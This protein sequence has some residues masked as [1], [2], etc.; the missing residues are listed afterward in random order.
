MSDT[1]ITAFYVTL[2]GEVQGIGLRR[3]I[4]AAARKRDLKGWVRN[5]K[6]GHVQLHVEGVEPEAR[7]LIA[8]LQ[9]GAIEAD[10]GDIVVTRTAPAGFEEFTIAKRADLARIV[11][12]L[13]RAALDRARRLEGEY[14]DINDTALNLLDA[15]GDDQSDLAE[16]M[17]RIP[18]RFL[19]EPFLQRQRAMQ[20]KISDVACSFASES[21]GHHAFQQALKRYIGY[22]PGGVIDNKARG[23]AFARRIG[24]RV[25]QTYQH[26]VPLSKIEIRAGVVIKPVRGAGSTGVFSV[27]TPDNIFS[28]GNHKHLSSLEEFESEA[29]RCA[30]TQKAGDRWMV[31]D[32]IL[33]ADG[34]LPNDLKMLT[35]YG[36]AV[37]VQES[38]RIPRRGATYYDR[39][40]N[41]VSTGRYEHLDFEGT[42]LLPEYI[43]I[44]EEVSLK[45][46]SP[47]NRIDFL[48][49]K[50][51]PVFGE[52]TPKPGNFQDFD[53]ATDAWLGREFAAAR[54]RLVADLMK[55]KRFTE[56]D[57][58][59]AELQNNS[60]AA[61]VTPSG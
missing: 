55:G 60:K 36:K 1:E 13:S 9:T 30:Q 57:A 59:V 39:D 14:A 15:G 33:D 3:R 28:L 50:D 34:N 21:W 27:L 2:H 4:R 41:K 56:F 44:A 7:R 35:F 10:I 26:D 49:S 12:A 31:E 40:G 32:L 58:F 54:A 61:P 45:I 16:L 22:A 17:R 42:G 43:A 8:D 5:R 11:P 51:G 38:T 18:C 25:P 20:F 24:L 52:F 53:A 46:P 19:G 47:F 37:L 48:K 29:R 23:Q 6:A